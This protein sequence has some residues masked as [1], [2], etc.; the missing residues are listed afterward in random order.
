MKNRVI[1]IGLDAADPVLLEKWMSQGRL[2][3]LKELRDR[4]AYGRLTNLSYY[5]AETPWTTFLTG[6]LPQKTGYWAPVKFYEGTYN[7]EEIGAYDFA[8]HPPFYAVGDEY[9]VAVFDMPQ[10]ILSDRVNGLQ[11]LAWG[12]HSPQTPSHSQPPEALGDIHRRHGKH[13]ALHR[14]HGD[15]WDKAYLDRLQKTLSQGIER[16]VAICRDLLNQEPW[17]LFLTVF[18]EPHSAGHDL[19][20]LSQSDHPLH[21]YKQQYTASEDPMLDVFEAVDR[22][23]SEILAEVPD[24]TYVVV[25]AAHG[26]DNNVT[27]VASMLFLPEFLYRFNFPGQVAIA[28]GNPGTPAPPMV[29]APRRKTWTGEIWERKFDP[30][31][32]KRFLRRQLPTKFHRHLDKIFG[33]SGEP[34]LLSPEQL[35][36]QGNSL[37]WNPTMWYSSYWPQMKA[38]ALPSYSEGYIRINLQGREPAGIVDSSEYDALCEEL[39]QQLYQLKNA[40][41]GGAIVKKVIRT[42]AGACDRDPKLPDADLVVVW[43]DPPADVIDHPE[44]GRIGPVPYRRTGS[45]R[46]RG[47][48]TVRGPGIAPGSDLPEGHG[49]DL[50]PTILKLM[51]APIPEYYD[52]KPLV[53]TSVLVS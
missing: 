36:Q 17:N 34:M 53:E 2:K 42:H 45:H 13:P 31:P 32:I 33:T 6:C 39:T 1:A 22:A 7:V 29:T 21:E 3:H 19:W 49:V 30:N 10:S 51:N 14:D 16:R 5:K 20:Y 44:F 41:T 48:L 35:R 46:E 43:Q 27:D 8:E 9:R 26:S 38:F 40:R 24:D 12:A 15:W 23:I 37:F 47:F 25:F 52:G 11:V 28:P 50:A 18:G 4:G